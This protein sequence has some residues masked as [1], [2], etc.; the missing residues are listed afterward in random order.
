M[1]L[2]LKQDVA[3]LVGNHHRYTAGRI[4][5]TSAIIEIGNLMQSMTEEVE[6]PVLDL[7]RQA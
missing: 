4:F 6:L 5:S 2:G 7:G 1:E 3:E